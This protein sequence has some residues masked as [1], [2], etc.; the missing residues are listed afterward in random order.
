MKPVDKRQ[1]NRELRCCVVNVLG[2]HACHVSS[3]QLESQN[4][5]TVARPRVIQLRFRGDGLDLKSCGWKFGSFCLYRS[6]N[7]HARQPPSNDATWK[8]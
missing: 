6:I 5:K 8:P 7:A 1:A 2:P 4:M 3:L